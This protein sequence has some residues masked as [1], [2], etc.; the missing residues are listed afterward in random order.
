MTIE[1]I[2]GLI[3]FTFVVM[4][5]CEIDAFRVSN[6][7]KD[8]QASEA[9]SDTYLTPLQIVRKNGYPGEAHIVESQDGYL[10]ELHRVPYG[11]AGPGINK[12]IPVFL[13]HGLLCSSMDWVINGPN[14]SLAYRLAD[15]GYDV[16]L[17]NARGNTFSR[18]H[19]KYSPQQREFWD[20]S[21]H[22]MGIYDVPA[23]IDHILATTGEEQLVYIGHSLGTTVFYVMASTLPEYSKKI[24]FH[25]SM[26]PVTAIPHTTSAFRLLVPY[27]QTIHD[28]SD[29]Y[30][31]G[32]FLE[33]DLMTKIFMKIFCG[34]K[35][36][37]TDVCEKY[38]IFSFFG[39]DPDQFNSSLVPVISSNV[40]AGTSGK[41]MIHCSQLI[42]SGTF[43]YYDYGKAENIKR[44]GAVI[45]PKYNMSK[46]SIPVKV[47]YGENDVL[48]TPIDTKLMYQK[49][50]KPLGLVRVN[51]DKFNHVD[52]L[53]AK[54]VNRL[55]NDELIEFIH[56]S[57]DHFSGIDFIRDTVMQA[58]DTRRKTPPPV[59]VPFD[60]KSFFTTVGN[61]ISGFSSLPMDATDL[62]KYPKFV[63]E[64]AFLGVKQ[65]TKEIDSAIKTAN[66]AM[67][68]AISDS[69]KQVQ[70]H[71][72]KFRSTVEDTGNKVSQTVSEQIANA[73]N[74][75]EKS[76]KELERQIR[77]SIEK[78]GKILT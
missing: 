1:K 50:P 19:V 56:N 68:S 57:T 12:R 65:V 59:N 11:K 72:D 46:I 15:E 44:Y 41:N 61:E 40:P 64:K 67:E 38:I 36:F 2:F 22:E 43:S 32:A 71:G 14:K 5:S 52:F 16:W 20:F 78:L 63:Q 49:I 60:E 13:H 77:E 75:V 8:L 45:P 48:S 28:M 35:I 74:A 70:I 76:T 39:K 58:L 42:S 55:L 34:T 73:Q 9:D 23:A 37:T 31:K 33:H 29:W 53:W 6:Y 51:F 54:D 4:N 3:V 21:F 24:K 66:S 18:G 7:F 27:A 69:I 30:N 26:A 47:Y 25:I 17:A 62:A 10:L